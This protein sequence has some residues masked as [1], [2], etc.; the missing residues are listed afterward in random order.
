LNPSPHRVLS[1]SLCCCGRLFCPH[2]YGRDTEWLRSNLYSKI[3]PRSAKGLRNSRSVG[4]GSLEVLPASGELDRDTT[5]SGSPQG[6]ETQS[7]AADYSSWG[8]RHSLS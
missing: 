7:H 5:F 3:N 2:D 4:D 6:R 1:V 8:G